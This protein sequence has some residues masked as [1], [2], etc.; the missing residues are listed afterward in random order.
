MS[1]FG[2]QRGCRMI[3]VVLLMICVAL[4]MIS[5]GTAYDWCGSADI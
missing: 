2:T 5:A 1:V 4:L 3:G